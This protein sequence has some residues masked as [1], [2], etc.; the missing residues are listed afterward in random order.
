MTTDY[1]IAIVGGSIDP[2]G[3]HN[4]LEPAALGKPV[5]VGPYTFN[6]ADITKQLLQ[7]KA[8]IQVPNQQELERSL[9]ELL[10][11][12]ERRDAMGQAGVS[13]VKTGQ[14]AVQRTLDLIDSALTEV[15]D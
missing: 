11:D 7:A 5:V 3:G 2:I 4:P 14:G 15:T 12:P 6:F 9:R 1:D 13:L 10:D 8:A